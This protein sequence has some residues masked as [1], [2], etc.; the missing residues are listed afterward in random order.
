VVSWDV[1]VKCVVF[2]YQECSVCMHVKS[3]VFVCEVQCLYACEVCSV[4]MHVKSEV[5]VCM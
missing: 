5:F 3:E 1:C 2:V 4:C